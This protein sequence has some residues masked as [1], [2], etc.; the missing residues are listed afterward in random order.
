[1]SETTRH[2]AWQAADSYDAYMGRWSRQLAPRFL[3][4]LNPP[5]ELE[6]LEVGCGTGALSSAIVSLCR[7]KSLISIDLSESFL[8]KAR[9]YVGSEL[10]EFRTGDAQSVNL[11]S[12]SRDVAVSGLVL[13]FVP[14]RASALAEMKRVTRPGGVVAYYVWDYPGGGLE[15]LRA[16]WNAAAALDPS[17]ENLKEDRR[18]PYCTPEGLMRMGKAAG[19]ANIEWTSMDIPTVFRD[20]EDYWRPFTLGAGPAPG[21]C[22]SLKPEDKERLKNKLHSTLLF[23]QDGSIPLKARAWAI[24]GIV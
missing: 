5:D 19:L 13:N 9:Q 21:Y 10:V 11:K 14:D 8:A 20:F 23:A 4:W 7:P 18:F 1:M 15:F 6:W 24:R 3:E 12:A 2:D 16:F 22:T 17:A